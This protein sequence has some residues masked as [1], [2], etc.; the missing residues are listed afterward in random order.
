MLAYCVRTTRCGILDYFTEKLPIYPISISREKSS[1]LF[2][3]HFPVKMGTYC[4]YLSVYVVQ[5]LLNEFS[6]LYCS[7]CVRQFAQ[8]HTGN[9][10]ATNHEA[11]PSSK[12]LII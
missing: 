10:K 8:G 11:V 12:D 1:F 4:T 6:G 5:V 3:L 2:L 9:G 7:F